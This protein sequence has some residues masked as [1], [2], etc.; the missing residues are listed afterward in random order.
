MASRKLSAASEPAAAVRRAV[1]AVVRRDDGLVLAMRRPDEPGEELP[2]VWGL[3][4]VTLR[5][6]E[7]PEEGVRRLGR[8]KLGVALTPLRAL[9]DGEQ[10][11]D[12]YTLRMTLY[13]ASLTGEPSASGG[14]RRDAGAAATLYDA[15]DWL[16]DA[17][18]AE[19]AARGSLC[20]SLL[21]EAAGSRQRLALPPMLRQ[22]TVHLSRT[23]RKEPTNAEA[24]LWQSLRNRRLGGRKFRRQ[25]PVGAFV[26]DFYC[27]EERLVIE[28][29]G[30]IH[31][32]RRAADRERQHLLEA[33][34]LR[35]V[36]VTNEDVEDDL[37]AVLRRIKACFRPSPGPDGHPSPARGRGARGEG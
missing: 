15:L 10:R 17:S 20:C 7:S 28:V 33:T 6:G 11:R 21:A 18:F 37:E 31:R 12:G 3:P 16:P 14:P 9:A 25:R 1:A 26:V 5:E 19:A 13:E 36:R 34:G 4:A 35:V 29:D 22:A 2:G 30:P 27:H 23:F 32:A 24:L 8:E